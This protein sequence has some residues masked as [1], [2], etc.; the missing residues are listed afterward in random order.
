MSEAEKVSEKAGV[1][2]ETEFVDVGTVKGVEVNQMIIKSLT[3]QSTVKALRIT[4]TKVSQYTSD[5]KI[6]VLDKDEID[7]LLLS[8]KQMQA[9]SNEGRDNYT[10][11]TFKSRTGFKA[12]MYFEKKSAKWSGY[13]EVGRIATATAFLSME[14]MVKFM[15][16]VS[17]VKDKM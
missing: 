5:T 12:G 17:A 1:L 2:V 14:D 8:L 11:V 13:L 3:D 9:M 10:E 6:S 16:F 15:G 7:G 4:Y